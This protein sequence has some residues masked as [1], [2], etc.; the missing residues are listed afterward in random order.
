LRISLGFSTETQ[1]QSALVYKIPAEVWGERPD[2]P[3]TFVEV[4]H[5]NLDDIVDVEGTFR[6]GRP[7]G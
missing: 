5:L 4:H 7:R 6:V 1:P 2:P 3:Q